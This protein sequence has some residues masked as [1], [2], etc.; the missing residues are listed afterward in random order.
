MA[1]KLVKRGNIWCYRLTDADG[2]RV[3]RKG[4]T[5]KRETERMAAAAGI[6]AAKIKTGQIT[7]KDLAYRDHESRPLVEHL[8]AYERGLR[9]NGGSKRYPETA[10]SKIRKFLELAK[11]RRISGL[12]LESALDAVQALRNEGLSQETIN[13]H[14]RAVKG[15][16]R[17][18]WKVKRSREHLLAHL[19]TASSEGDRRRVRRALTPEE[20]VKVIQAAEAGPAFR[21]LSG[22]DRAILYALALGTGFRADELRTLTPERFN[23]DSAPP[24]VTA[25]ACYTK[26][27]KEAVQPI[28]TGLAERLGPWLAL[29]APG[30]PVFH[31]MTTRTAEMLRVDL[32]AAG[33]PYETDSGVVDFH[34]LRG[35]YIS[36][37]I[38]S[39]ASVKTCQTL[40]RHSSPS[41]TIGIYAKA[42]LHDISGAVENLPDLTPRGSIAE[43]ETLSATGTDGANHRQTLAPYLLHSGDVSSHDLSSSDAIAGSVV[44]MAMNANPLENELSDASSHAR[45]SSDSEDNQRSKIPGLGMRNPLT[46]TSICGQFCEAVTSS[47]P[48]ESMTMVSSVRAAP[49]LG[50]QA[51]AMFGCRT[52]SLSGRRRTSWGV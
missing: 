43:R 47:K 29:K 26:N 39:G 10:A 2:K 30:K 5:D 24:T 6:E 15:F 44:P 40:A 25:S 17:W 12:S 41:L 9:A 50:L 22:P 52:R 13:H 49:T 21:G 37:L 38:S 45:A 32:E 27:G 16:S 19:A 33:I 11:V 7:P 20:A 42:S 18:L 28:A 36:Y 14:I 34:S 8:E 1:E 3:M 51:S 31:P 46:A 4:C 35:C 23:L 48:R